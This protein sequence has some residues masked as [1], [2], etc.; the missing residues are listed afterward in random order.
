MALNICRSEAQGPFEEDVLR[1][2]SQLYPHLRRAL[3]L[4]F[5]LDGYKTLQRA[6]FHVLDRLSAGIVL[7]DR[8]ARVVFAN[9]AA[10]AM[11]AHD[12]PLRLRNSVLAAASAAH[13]HQLG[14]LIGAA[15][16]GDGL[17]QDDGPAAPARWPAVHC[18]GLI[19][20]QP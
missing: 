20:A 14:E 1:L 3:L 2:F 10:R 16:C 6:E 9:A 12:G 8:S 5:R 17:G 13:S 15:V 7:L 19:R 18:P 11:T 4:G